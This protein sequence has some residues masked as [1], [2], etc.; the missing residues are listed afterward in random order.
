MAPIP[1]RDASH[2]SVSPLAPRGS[3]DRSV[4]RA[5]SPPAAGNA[6]VRQRSEQEPNGTTRSQERALHVTPISCDVCHT[7]AVR[8]PLSPT[9]PRTVY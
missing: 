3:G 7:L 1:L 6:R 9:R 8:A 4:G 5:S 2:G